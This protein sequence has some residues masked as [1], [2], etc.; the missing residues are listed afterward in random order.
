MAGLRRRWRRATRTG[1][2]RAA[3]PETLLVEGLA[4]AEQVLHRP[5]Q[6]RRQDGQRLAFAAL[7]RLLLLPLLGP[8]TRA[9]QQARRLGEGPTQMGVADLLAARA[10]LLARRLVGAAD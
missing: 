2:P 8:L 1:A 3:L 5:P 10:Q 4:L 7:G 9:Q 6:P